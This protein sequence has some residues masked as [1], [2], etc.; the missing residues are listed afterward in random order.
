MPLEYKIR[1]PSLKISYSW[2]M[3]FLFRHL[4]LW[5][6]RN[7]SEYEH[8]SYSQILQ[9]HMYYDIKRNNH[10]CCW[11]L[12]LLNWFKLHKMTINTKHLCDLHESCLCAIT[13]SLVPWWLLS[14][15]C[16]CKFIS[17]HSNTSSCINFRR[18]SCSLAVQ[19]LS[20]R[21]VSKFKSDFY[22]NVNVF[23]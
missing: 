18:T 10:F 17:K 6:T 20:K 9:V 4:G 15:K 16:L 8:C 5:H 7:W 19:N 21:T 12:V 13:K 11:T 23:F 1:F 14:E 3:G 22:D 2:Y